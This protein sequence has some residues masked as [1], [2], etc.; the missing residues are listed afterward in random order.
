MISGEKADGV[1]AVLLTILGAIPLAIVC[2]ASP[3]HGASSADVELAALMQKLSEV[4]SAEGK[5]TERKFFSIL[6]EPLILTGRVVYQAPDYVRKEY[7]DP[8][9][10]SYEVRGQNLTIEY[11]DGRRRALSI[12]DHPLLR[13]FVESYRGTLA[14]DLERLHRYFDLEVAGPMDAWQLRLTPR[15]PELAERLSAVVMGGREGTVYS[16]ETLE[17]SGDRSVMTVEPSSE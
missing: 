16:V 10:E 13:A 14:G 17:A 15:N 5:F 2:A 6:N 12:D 3:V 8:G 9:S 7:D 4:R 1:A 11:P